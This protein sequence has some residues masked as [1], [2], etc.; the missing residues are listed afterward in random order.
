MAFDNSQLTPMGYGNGYTHYRYDTADTHATVDTDAYFNNSD[1]TVNLR[2]GDIIDVFVWTTSAGT[3]PLITY[4]RHV[5]L[6]VTAGVVD[7]SDVT[8]G[9]M[10]D[11]D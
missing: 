10:T 7:V 1:D 9:T 6:S 11:T 3:S 4:G 8:V 5:V 2:A